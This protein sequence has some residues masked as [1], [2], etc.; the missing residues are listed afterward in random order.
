M[1]RRLSE[2][3]VKRLTRRIMGVRGVRLLPCQMPW[4]QQYGPIA[5]E[6]FPPKWIRSQSCECVKRVLLHMYK[7]T[8][9][10]S[11]EGVDDLREAS[12]LH[13]A[14][15]KRNCRQMRNSVNKEFEL[16]FSNIL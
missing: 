4:E 9:V 7:V 6:I 16:K 2:V 13:C 12:N 10:V 11:E 8:I 1:Y 3:V 5:L 15:A 14:F